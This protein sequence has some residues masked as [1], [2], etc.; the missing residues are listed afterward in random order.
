MLVK[1]RHLKDAANKD[2]SEFV[3]QH[4]HV[5][6]K[7]EVKDPL[8]EKMEVVE[9]KYIFAGDTMHMK[10]FE[11][12]TQIVTQL[13]IPDTDLVACRDMVLKCKVGTKKVKIRGDDGKEKIVEVPDYNQFG[14]WLECVN[15]PEKVKKALGI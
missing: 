1:L 3:D 12:G 10:N 13:E 9:Q 5:T 6:L 15:I 11:P 14:K 2:R 4:I 7:Q 8:T